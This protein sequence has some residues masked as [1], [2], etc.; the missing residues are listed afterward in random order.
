MKITTG[1]PLVA[2]LTILLTVCLLNVACDDPPGPS[3]DTQLH[4][5]QEV[6]EKQAAAQLGLPNIQNFRMKRTFKQ[7]KELMDQ[8]GLV[9]YAYTF[10]EMSGKYKFFCN[11]IGYPIPY[12]TQYTNPEKIAEKNVNYGYAIIPQADPDGLF[13]PSSAEGTLVMCKDPNSD[14]VLPVY[15]EPKLI[16]SPFKL[17]TDSTPVQAEASK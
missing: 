15:S 11:S 14:K 5:K 4:R 2:L 12:A 16:V 13:Y 1:I 10:S 9:T 3:A 7:I 8:D 17:P 6:L